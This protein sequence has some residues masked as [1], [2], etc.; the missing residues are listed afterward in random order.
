MKRH[1]PCQTFI[2]FWDNR[3]HLQVGIFIWLMR[4]SSYY[5]I[6]YAWVFC[7]YISWSIFSRMMG[8]K[9]ASHCALQRPRS[10]S[11]IF[12]WDQTVY[13]DRQDREYYPRA[14]IRGCTLSRPRYRWCGIFLRAESDMG[15]YTPWCSLF[16]RTIC[17]F[18]IWSHGTGISGSALCNTVIHVEKLLCWSYSPAS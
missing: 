11:V 18:M 10:R 12:Q 4:V 15:K 13:S 16:D 8:S 7:T 14:C 9:S 6:Q 17:P 2:H 1:T 3:V 5:V